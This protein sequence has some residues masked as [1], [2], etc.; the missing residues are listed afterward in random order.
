MEPHRAR[1]G[2]LTFLASALVVVVVGYVWG[3][4]AIR[5]WSPSPS[6]PAMQSCIET[7]LETGDY[8]PP[9]L[10]HVPPD[11]QAH[12]ECRTEVGRARRGLA[13]DVLNGSL[14]LVAVGSVG[15]A[16]VRG[17]RRRMEASTTSPGGP[18]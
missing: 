10:A 8:L 5:T 12:F 11:A 1:F 7:K 16:V 15:T 2:S 17:R 13:H 4:E 9:R 6:S 14:L 18:S 3:H